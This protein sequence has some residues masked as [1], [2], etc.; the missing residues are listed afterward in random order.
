MQ[1]VNNSEDWVDPVIGMRWR[2][3][4]AENWVMILKGDIGGFGVASNFTWNQQGGVAWD[5]T[6]YMSLV[7]E[8][9]ALSVDYSSGDVGSR[10]FFVYD[11]ITHGPLFGLAFHW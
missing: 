4:I 9:R 8:Y 10:E 6:D 2:P 11:T 5:A 1:K 3:Q 7:L